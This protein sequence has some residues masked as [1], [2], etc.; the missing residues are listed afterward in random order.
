VGLCCDVKVARAPDERAARIKVA[1]TQD[2]ALD[3]ERGGA[4]CAREGRRP[5]DGLSWLWV[6]DSSG[7]TAFYLT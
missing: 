2:G 6:T 4:A 1:R 5:V 3:G 7:P